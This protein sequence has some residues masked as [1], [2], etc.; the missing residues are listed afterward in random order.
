MI[1]AD[2]FFDYLP[3]SHRGDL[4]FIIK[5]LMMLLTGGMTLIFMKK[6]M[7]SL[8]DIVL[9]ADKI[10]LLNPF[11]ST[12]EEF[13]FSNLKNIEFSFGKHPMLYIYLKNQPRLSNAHKSYPM[14][15]L[16]LNKQRL[17]S[18]QVADIIHQVFE[19]YQNN[20]QQMIYLREVKKDFFDWG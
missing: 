7:N 16:K 19:S 4:P 2:V 17:H 10:K 6:I 12:Y 3:P 5:L 15:Y 18:R 13:Q 9:Y 11:K 8:P 20:T 14:V 1:F